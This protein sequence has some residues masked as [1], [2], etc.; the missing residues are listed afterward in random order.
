MPITAQRTVTT[1]VSRT[2]FHKRCAVS[3]RQIRCQTPVDAGT[4]GLGQQ[5]HE[6][7]RE[8][9]DDKEAE[10]KEHFG[11]RMRRGAT[12]CPRRRPLPAS[13]TARRAERHRRGTASTI[14]AV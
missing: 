14:A 1:T 9:R 6:R 7:E 5:E 10:T 3:E 13:K 8:R 4:G 11:R 2:V 12:W